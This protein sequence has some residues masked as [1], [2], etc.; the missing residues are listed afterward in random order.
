MDERLAT[1]IMRSSTSYTPPGTNLRLPRNACPRADWLQRAAE[2]VP[3]TP[4]VTFVNVGANKGYSLHEFMSLW[5]SLNLTARLWHHEIR[6]WGTYVSKGQSAGAMLRQGSCGNCKDCKQPVLAAHSRRGGEAHVFEL[7]AANRRLLRHLVQ[8]TGIATTIHDFAVSN[9]SYEL[10]QRP[11]FAGDERS[12]LDPN[13]V[14]PQCTER[15]AV[16]TL[17]AFFD[18]AALRQVYHVVIDTEGADAL[19][20][21][22]MQR[23]LRERRVSIVEFEVSSRGAW[24]RKAG[25]SLGRTVRW[26]HRLGYECF[27]QS[28]MHLL[29]ISPPCW[30]TRH[31]NIRPTWA[32]LACTHEAKLRALMRSYA[33]RA[34]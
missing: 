4:P 30:S 14:G 9:R 6:R 21:E 19:V 27:W 31:D 18:S 13:C 24:S 32:N 2:L 20:L 3:R 5:S 15:V 12:G 29:P 23:S 1:S 17:D 11:V 26:L 25:G 16:T 34:A 7:G 28:G 33:P 22:G 8:T 10:W